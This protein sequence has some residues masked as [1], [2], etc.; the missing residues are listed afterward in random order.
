MIPKP[1]GDEYG[2]YYD[3]YIQKVPASGPVAALDAQRA[4]IAALGGLSEEAAERRYAEG[5][6]SVKEVIGHLSDA[7]QVFT[8]RLLRIARADS[9]P[10]AGFD[11]NAW[12]TVAPHHRGPVAD[13]VSE[14]LAVREATLAL[15]RSL[16]EPSLTRQTVANNRAISG[17][18]ICWILAGHTEHHLAILRDR[19]KVGTVAVS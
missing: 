3:G 6:W 14:L 16:D 5:K 4:A 17:R 8:Y 15:V 10:L 11:E 19:Y 7:E 18:A 9:T 12:Q 13:L 1:N 2:T